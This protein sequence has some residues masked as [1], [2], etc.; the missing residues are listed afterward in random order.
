MKP[1]RARSAGS[2]RSSVKSLGNSVP[3]PTAAKKSAAARTGHRAREPFADKAYRELRAR[4]LD[5]SMPSGEQYTEDELASMLDMSRTPTR[6]AML[7]LAGEGLV[8]VRP[9]HGMRVKPVSVVDMR[10]IY[11][12]LTALE[13][14]AAALAAARTDQGDSIKQ[15][16]HAIS[17][18]DAA[19]KL[20]DLK[21]WARADEQFHTLLVAAAGNAR[22]SELVQT[23]VGQSHRVRMLTLRLRAKPVMSNRDHEAVVDAVEAHDAKRAREIHF[24]HR[25]QSGKMLVELL[26]GHGLTQL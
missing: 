1:L 17:E 22:L 6:E 8:E 3:K 9:R 19:L 23:Y 16:R 11:E 24:S 12:V 10:E 7:R 26:V 25:E 21:A 18:M 14:T 20:D 5:N 4:I 15:L 2:P 13:S